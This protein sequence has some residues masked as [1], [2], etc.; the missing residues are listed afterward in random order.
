[1]HLAELLPI[2]EQPGPRAWIET[3]PSGSPL[4]QFTPEWE[5]MNTLKPPETPLSEMVRLLNCW[6]AALYIRVLPL[7]DTVAAVQ[8]RGATRLPA[9]GLAPIAKAAKSK[10]A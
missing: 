6:P 7:T 9:A 10:P 5:T 1:M 4:P 2:G 8:Q 3:W